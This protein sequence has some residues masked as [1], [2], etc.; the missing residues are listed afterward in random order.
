MA[1]TVAPVSP[2]CRMAQRRALT[3]EGEPSIP[4]TIRGPA[5]CSSAGILCS[6][7][8]VYLGLGWQSHGWPPPGRS[9]HRITM[10]ARAHALAGY[11]LGHQGQYPVGA[12]ARREA[13]GAGARHAGP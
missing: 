1:S 13:G 8:L 11:A 6:L 12:V 9:A 5:R 4:A 2:A 3:D 7:Y 10:R